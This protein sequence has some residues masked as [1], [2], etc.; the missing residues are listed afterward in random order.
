MTTESPAAAVRT[1]PVAV[2]RGI[3]KRYR[4]DNTAVLALDGVDLDIPPARFTVITGPSGS[5]K[6]TLLHLLGALDRADAGTLHVDGRDLA[7]LDDDALSAFRARHIGFV[8]QSF[9]LLP[10]LT[11]LENVE[12]PL[13]LGMLSAAARRARALDLLGAVGLADKARHRPAELSGGQRQRV[14]IARALANSPRLLLADEP[15]ANLDRATGA[16][17][18]ALLRRLQ[19]ETGTSVVFSSH[20]A[21]VLDAADLRVTLVDGRVARL[22]TGAE[23]AA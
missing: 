6:S 19:R 2:L 22:E 3:R 18:I 12:Y 9:N 4:L 16:G 10:V 13:R 14:A 1:E 21:A 8:F 5:G 17:I 23:V 15:T 20:D 7:R 11:A